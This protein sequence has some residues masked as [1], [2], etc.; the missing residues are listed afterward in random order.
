MSKFGI[1]GMMQIWADELEENTQIRVN[2]INP[3]ATRTAMRR[4]AYPVEDPQTLPTPESIMP[5]YLYLM[6]A[7][8]KQ[9]NGQQLSV[10]ETC[11]EDV[12]KISG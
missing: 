5:L 11:L 9:V 2:S 4:A 1:E 12:S 6:G 7:D 3:G 10:R 8:S